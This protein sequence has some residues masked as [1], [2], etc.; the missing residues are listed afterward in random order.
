MLITERLG[1]A[2]NQENK[3]LGTKTFMFQELSLF[4][5]NEGPLESDVAM[6]DRSHQTLCCGKGSLE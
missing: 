2:K 3:S 6:A 5:Q 1:G 4:N